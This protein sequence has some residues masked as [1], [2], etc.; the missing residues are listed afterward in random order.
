[1]LGRLGHRVRL[2]PPQYVKP[3]VKRAKN[4]RNDAEAI[5]EAASRLSMRSVPVSLRNAAM[6]T[7]PRQP[8]RVDLVPRHQPLEY[9][10][11]R[12]RTVPRPAAG[13]L[14]IPNTARSTATAASTW[15]IRS[16]RWPWCRTQS[17]APERREP[18]NPAGQSRRSGKHRVTSPCYG[19]GAV[20]FNAANWRSSRCRCSCRCRSPSA[21]HCRC[22]TWFAQDGYS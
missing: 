2:I 10:G 8:A 4:D 18:A 12:T 14:Q 3:C 19:T 16:W 20:S 1:M 13:C 7:R 21:R 5:S 9:G 22:P 11:G 15:P 17:N 6:P